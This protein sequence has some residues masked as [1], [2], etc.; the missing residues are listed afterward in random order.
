MP[1]REHF[2]EF[3]KHDEA[4]MRYISN[5]FSSTLVQ[6]SSLENQVERLILLDETMDE[7]KP[8]F[9]V[10]TTTFPTLNRRYL[11]PCVCV[12]VSGTTR[13]IGSFVANDTIAT[14]KNQ[15]PSPQNRRQLKRV[16]SMRL[17]QAPGMRRNKKADFQRWDF[18][19]FP[20][21]CSVEEILDICIRILEVALA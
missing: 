3:D 15:A 10:S 19:Y 14:K 20:E 13:Y 8:F 12:C 7:G 18:M 1:C 16:M 6:A 4:M 9:K 21:N 11:V 2:V 17:L 5:E